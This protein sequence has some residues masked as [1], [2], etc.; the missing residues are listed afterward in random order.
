MAHEEWMAAPMPPDETERLAALREYHILDTPAEEEF[1]DLTWLASFICQAPMAL[2]TLIDHHRQWF[3]ARVGFDAPESPRAESICAHAV[4]KPDKVFEVPDA[5]KDKRFAG[6][7]AIAGGPC[8]RFYAGAPL[9]GARGHAVGTICVM[10]REP[11]T[12][13]N[14]QRRALRILATQAVAL[15]EKRVRR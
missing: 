15:L 14:D 5:S 13:S 4:L 9:V 3:K 10:D 12:L 7:P 6:M 11:R 1:D 2:V 8:V